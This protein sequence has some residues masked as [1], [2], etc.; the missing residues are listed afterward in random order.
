MS[1]AALISDCL[2]PRFLPLSFHL[3]PSE[4]VD[5]GGEKKGELI[6]RK[7]SFWGAI[8]QLG[9]SILQGHC[10][11]AGNQMRCLKKWIAS[12]PIK[13]TEAIPS[14]L[15][16]RNQ[17]SQKLVKYAVN[18]SYPPPGNVLRELLQPFGMGITT[19]WGRSSDPKCEK[20]SLQMGV[21]SR[22]IA[23]RCFSCPAGKK[24][25]F[26]RAARLWI[27]EK[28]QE[29]ARS[30]RSKRQPAPSGK[31]K[32]APLLSR[33]SLI[34]VRDIEWANVMFSFEQESR[35]QIID[36]CYPQSPVGF[37]QE[38]SNVIFRQLLRGRRPFIAYMF[39][40]MGNEVLR[41]HRPFWWINSTIYAEVDGKE[42]GV[43]H[44]RWHLWRR[45][46]DL[47]LGNKQFAVV[48]NP[49][50]WNW[51]F[52]LRD[53]EGNVLA[54]IDRNWRGVGLELFTDAGQYVVRFGDADSLPNNRPGS[55]E[56]EVSRPLTLSE[57]AV[58]IALAVSLD[59]DYFSRS[60]GGW[61]FPFLVAE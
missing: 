34:I 18:S 27:E 8:E 22:L 42:V 31:V 41:V 57:R 16:F 2:R 54:Q 10:S 53:E 6:C 59:S 46:Y 25:Y 44:R 50:F 7:G 48:E 24:Q 1:G 49:G 30:R 28:Q 4:S 14:L 23:H 47:Y 55:S 13:F 11:V 12:P 36:P 52:T 9:I 5:E 21:N 43:V 20:G 38:K 32:L 40:A 33:D 60:R 58:A 45:I 29:K 51:T 37:I 17:G 26:S 39:D 19:M 15:A 35:Y 56:F 61:A 3:K